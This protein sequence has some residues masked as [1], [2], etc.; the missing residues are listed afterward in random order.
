MDKIKLLIADDHPI[1]RYGLRDILGL[2]N[3]FLVI[4]EASNGREVVIK[5]LKYS[6]DII[7]MD[8]FMPEITGLQTIEKL[9]GEITSI[10][11]IVFTLC[12]ESEYIFKT[13][14]L[15][16]SG[17]VLKDSDPKILID[18]IRKVYSGETY[19]QQS[20][21]NELVH[22]F[23]RFSQGAN[24]YINDNSCLTRREIE[25][26]RL[27]TEG[28]LNKEIAIKLK[29]SEKTVKNH[30]ANIFRKLNV[31]DRTQAAIYAFKHKL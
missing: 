13:I 6:P 26:I 1:F 24:L 14:N 5:A 21:L 16:A 9:M 25:V 30:V 15:G 31:S 27:L 2:Q 7:L 10:R 4:G 29:I 20:L 8:L 3:D 17:Y 28:L 18:A 12:K 19:I 22:E 23:N 11:I